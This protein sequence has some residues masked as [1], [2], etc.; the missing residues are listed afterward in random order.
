M[1]KRRGSQSTSDERE[2]GESLYWEKRRDSGSNSSSSTS[3]SETFKLFMSCCVV[4]RAKKFQFCRPPSY[5]SRRE[6]E[7]PFDGS[8]FPSIPMSD[9]P[10][11]AENFGTSGC[12]IRPTNLP[13]H[14]LRP[15]FLASPAP[16]RLA[17]SSNE[18]AELRLGTQNFCRF[19]E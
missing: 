15:R 9:A 3:Q 16:H 2:E 1:E 6:G 8:L 18:V 4:A 7:R 13:R 17:Y 14:L 19:A 12:D 11:L 10:S 5:P